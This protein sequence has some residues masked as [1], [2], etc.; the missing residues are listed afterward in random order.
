MCRYSHLQDSDARDPGRESFTVHYFVRD[1]VRED[2]RRPIQFTRTTEIPGT[3]MRAKQTRIVRRWSV[4][5]SSQM[6]L[7]HTMPETMLE[8]RVGGTLFLGGTFGETPNLFFLLPR[9]FL[10]G[11]AD[12][13]HPPSSRCPSTPDVRSGRRGRRRCGRTGVRTWTR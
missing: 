13:G 10:V 4:S 7:L 5:T 1:T 9:D 12:E 3:A 11:S 2:G 8:L 6:S